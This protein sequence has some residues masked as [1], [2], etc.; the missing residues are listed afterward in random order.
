MVR[1]FIALSALAAAG[2]STVRIV[3]QPLSETDAQSITRE[4]EGK[5]ASIKLSDQARSTDGADVLVT[6]AAV[7]WN[8]SG[9]YGQPRMQVPPEAIER[10]TIRKRGR[11]ALDGI[12]LGFG[13]GV[14]VGLL[15]G[16]TRGRE[17]GLIAA[18]GAVEVGV[19]SALIL[20]FIGGA[21]GH[22]YSIELAPSPPP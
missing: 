9:S 21:I 18:I 6:P 3:K 7:E 1:S 15:N 2:C 16:A 19:A 22:P 20:A 5:A 8:Q 13:I 4:L 14:A 11:G 17:S 10:I 12:F